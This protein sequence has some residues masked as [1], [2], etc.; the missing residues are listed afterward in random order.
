MWNKALYWQLRT[1]WKIKLVENS[2][3]I[4]FMDGG[5]T[6]KS[7]CSGRGADH[8]AKIQHSNPLLWHPEDDEGP[9]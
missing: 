5:D 2:W 6:V 8:G 9:Q 3:K 1:L 4:K 7:C